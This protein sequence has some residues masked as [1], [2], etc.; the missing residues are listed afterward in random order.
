[1][2]LGSTVSTP[3]L[4]V[5]REHPPETPPDFWMPEHVD[6]DGATVPR[7]MVPMSQFRKQ[8]W[9]IDCPDCGQIHRCTLTM[10]AV[11][12]A[13]PQ[14]YRRARAMSRVTLI[15]SPCTTKEEG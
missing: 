2:A 8:I 7:H 11:A 9:E 1:M 13:D 3:A 4:S 10:R 5:I 12:M 14:L 6:D 15:E